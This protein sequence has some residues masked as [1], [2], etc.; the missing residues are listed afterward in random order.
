MYYAIRDRER[1]LKGD[2]ERI[3]GA[4]MDDYVSKPVNM[5]ELKTTIAQVMA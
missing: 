4:G 2:R 5:E 1:D 3:L